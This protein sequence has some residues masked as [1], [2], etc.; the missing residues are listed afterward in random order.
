MLGPRSIHARE[1]AKVL[2]VVKKPDTAVNGSRAAQLASCRNWRAHTMYS[3]TH[4]GTNVG[5]RQ[6]M[7]SKLINEVDTGARTVFEGL[8]HSAAAVRS[9]IR[10]LGTARGAHPLH[11]SAYAAD[12]LWNQRRA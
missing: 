10:N 6:L 9:A 4:G 11:P 3:V 8:I 12:G 1:D 7:C 5:T 2:C